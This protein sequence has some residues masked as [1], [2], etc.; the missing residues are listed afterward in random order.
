M[1]VYCKLH[2]KILEAQL[3]LA[4]PQWIL[5]FHLG[6]LFFLLLLFLSV[7]QTTYKALLDLM[8]P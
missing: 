1:R 6:K 2:N 4:M 5:H 7:I 3:C 8:P